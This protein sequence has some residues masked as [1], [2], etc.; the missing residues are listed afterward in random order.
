M[1]GLA[2]Y[3]SEIQTGHISEQPPTPLLV[4]LLSCVR[5][6]RPDAIC[7]DADTQSDD[8]QHNVTKQL[9]A[10][11]AQLEA[12]IEHTV[13]QQVCQGLMDNAL[14]LHLVKCAC[15]SPFPQRNTRLR[16]PKQHGY[17]RHNKVKVHVWQQ[18]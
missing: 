1:H 10:K 3:T 6:H 2:T 15:T 5:Q 13:Q 11:L 7:T 16:Q 18:L 17:K 9:E 14:C 8:L 4:Q 12:S